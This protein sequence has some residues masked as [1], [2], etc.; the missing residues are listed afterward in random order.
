LDRIDESLKTPQDRTLVAHR[1]TLLTRVQLHARQS[2]YDDALAAAESLESVANRSGDHLLRTMAVLTKAEL[3]QQM[4][5]LEESTATLDAIVTDLL[6]NPPDLYAQYERI[7]AC[8]LAASGHFDAARTHYARSKRMYTAL[9]NVPGAMELSRC[10]DLAV[11]R[12]AE[13]AD[14]TTRADEATRARTIL[15]RASAL[16]LHAARPDLLATEI[17]DMLTESECV[18]GAVAIARDN[19]G[20]VQVLASSGEA[21]SATTP[22]SGVKR[23]A[24]GVDC[25]RTVELLL[26]P[27]P[28]VESAATLNA[29]TILLATVH[30]LQRARAERE[31]RLTLWPIDDVQTEDGRA[32]VSGHMREVMTFAR[33]IATT[34]VSVLITGESGTGKEI[35]ARAIHSFSDRAKKPFIPF[36]CTAIPHEMLESQLFGHRRG[37]FTGADRDNPGLIRSAREGTLFLDEVGELGLDLQPKLLRFLEAGEICP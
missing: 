36:N 25:D 17:V 29:I 12:A 8:A 30:D 2:Q 35:V 4:N 16:M 14:S 26:D 15:Q 20:Q 18:H 34:T 3:L 28:D 23:I 24:V 13:P 1:H 6:V 32:V 33:R 21:P 10:W 37:S 19:S 31:E 27:R 11:S 9:S 22:A 7:L 5:R